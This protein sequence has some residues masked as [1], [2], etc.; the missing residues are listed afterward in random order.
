[1]PNDLSTIEIA[2]CILLGTGILLILGV[3]IHLSRRDQWAAIFRFPT[4]PEHDIT[5]LDLLVSIYAFAAMASLTVSLLL[6]VWGPEAADGAAASQPAEDGLMSPYRVLGILSG[7]VVTTAILLVIGSIRFRQGLRGWGLRVRAFGRR[8][9]TAALA[10]V[11]LWPVC[12]GV[13]LMVTYVYSFFP[14]HEIIEHPSIRALRD[15]TAPLYVVVLTIVSAV[16]LAPLVEEL[17]FRGLILPAL[18]QSL[19]STGK[20]VVFSG[21]AFGLVH[22]QVAHQVPALAVLGMILGYAYAKT[23]SLTLVI[24]MHAIFN[25]KTILWL[26]LSGSE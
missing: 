21:I 3:A 6:A 17:L 4:A 8:V 14:A 11:A 10:Y 16:C 5:L 1:M 19:G 25:A 23:R 18:E 26:L 22:L 20:A 24:L 2:E 7:Q 9:R 15:G 13:L 12:Y